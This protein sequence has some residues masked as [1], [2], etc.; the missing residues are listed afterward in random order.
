MAWQTELWDAFPQFRNVI[1]S[2]LDDSGVT[3]CATTK[4]S[5]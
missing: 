5:L 3:A 2:S 1:L 4:Y